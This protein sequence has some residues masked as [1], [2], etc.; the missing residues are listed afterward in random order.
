M[1]PDRAP[2][3]RR[4]L[5]ALVPSAALGIAG[6]LDGPGPNDASY[7]TPGDGVADLD[8]D[9][10]LDRARSAGY[11]VE[12]PFYVNARARIGLPLDV[13]ALADR[14]GEAARAVLVRFHYSGTRFLEADFTGV[15]APRLVAVDE[16]LGVEQP[17]RP[18][19]LPPDDWLRAQIELL[20]PDGDAD[21]LAAELGTEASRTEEPYAAVGV[22]AAP[23]FAGTHAA[24]AERAT[25]TTASATQGDGWVDLAFA[26]D[27]A[28]FGSF[29]IVVPSARIATTDSGH[30]YEIK[31]DRAG[32]FRLRVTLPAGETIPESEYRGVFRGMFETVGLPAQRVAGYEFEYSPSVW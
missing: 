16:E 5:T 2:S 28:R 20:F 14:F 22:D 1:S 7:S 3:R 10:V 18:V 15:T 11:S 26:A 17:F 25:E 32:G 21:A 6:C 13:P 4:F 31:L 19:N 27:G 23:D 30:E 29:A 12:A 24:F 8:Y 9:A